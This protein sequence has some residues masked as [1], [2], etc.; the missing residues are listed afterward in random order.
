MNPIRPV[1]RIQP[2]RPVKEAPRRGEHPA[3]AP[4]G[5]SDGPADVQ[6]VESVEP[7]GRRPKPAP[8]PGGIDGYA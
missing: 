2:P 8:R 5:A 7:D 1:D 3:P 6:P 4:E